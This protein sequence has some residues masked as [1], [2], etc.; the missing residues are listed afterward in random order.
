MSTGTESTYPA[1]YD[2]IGIGFGPSN[3]A[4]SGAL[5]E[6]WTALSNVS[7]SQIREYYPNKLH[8][9]RMQKRLFKRFF[10]LRG[11]HHSNGILECFFQEPKCK[12][13]MLY[14]H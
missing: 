6:K 5:V 3:I 13:G 8:A 7:S 10:S 1:V 4:I 11:T 14:L 2:L 12:L 9:S